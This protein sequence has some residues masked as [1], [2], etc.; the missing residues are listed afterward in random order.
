VEGAHRQGLC[1]LLPGLPVIIWFTDNALQQTTKAEAGQNIK[2][3][4][5]EA[6]KETIETEV[7]VERKIKVEPEI[8]TEEESS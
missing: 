5:T 8:K 4:P 2:K 3:E 7:K 6:V 1:E